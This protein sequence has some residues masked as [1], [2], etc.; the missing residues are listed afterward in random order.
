MSRQVDKED[1]S[2]Y[3]AYKDIYVLAAKYYKDVLTEAVNNTMSRT[4]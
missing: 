1:V 4:R 3:L 2:T